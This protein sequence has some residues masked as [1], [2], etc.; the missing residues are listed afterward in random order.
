MS[1]PQLRFRRL[2]ADKTERRTQCSAGFGTKLYPI[3]F[4]S[5]RSLIDTECAYGLRYAELNNREGNNPWS[6]RQTAFYHKYTAA[7]KSSSWIMIAAS[8]RIR[9]S[10]DLYVKSCTDLALFNPF[11]VHV[12]VLDSALA[13]WR[14]YIID[15]TERI[16]LQVRMLALLPFNSFSLISCSRKKCLSHL[17]MGQIQFSFSM[18]ESHFPL[19]KFQSWK[20]AEVDHNLGR[21]ASAIKRI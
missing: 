4:A 19:F 14:S 7:D 13:N 12:L 21:G 5:A 8:E 20:C 16:T 15:L 10:L 18:Y 3:V 11:E 1:P 17:L 6:I 2:A 9:S